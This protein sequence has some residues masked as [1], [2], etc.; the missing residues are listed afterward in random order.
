[1]PHFT[2]DGCDLY[3]EMNGKTGPA[4]VLAHGRGGNAASWWQQV[5][6]F[7]DDHRVITIDHRGFARSTC[8]D[9]HHLD[10]FTGDMLALLDHLE[11]DR[12]VLV[13]QSMGGRTALGMAVHHPERVS[14]IVLSC[15]AAGL[16]IPEVEATQAA[17]QQIPRGIEAPTAALAPSFREAQPAMTFLYEQLRAMSPPQGPLFRESL[18]RLDGGVTPADLEGFAIPTLVISG[19][20]DPLYPHA[21]LEAVTAAIPGARLT[22]LPGAGHS[23]Y[24]E[25]PETFNALV[26]DFVAGLRG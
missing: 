6:A 25:M 2:H 12:A 15:T 16:M 8:A 17:R 3:Y 4:L 5:P 19:E 23:P 14:G 1:M 10:H 20:H 13:G 22:H 24:W 7:R 26:R 21:V 18:A 9:G 11:V